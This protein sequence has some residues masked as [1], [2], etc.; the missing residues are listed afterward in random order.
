MSAASLSASA[1]AEASEYSQ[2][3]VKGGAYCFASR[4]FA[5]IVAGHLTCHFGTCTCRKPTAR[6]KSP[7][8]AYLI[9]K[10][11]VSTQTDSIDAAKAA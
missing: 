9:Q 1:E 5:R 7:Q 10:R 8:I 3:K 11:S 4:S 6:T 2:L